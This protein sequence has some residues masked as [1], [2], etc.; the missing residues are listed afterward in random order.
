MS[1][2]VWDIRGNSV[3]IFRCSYDSEIHLIVFTSEYICSSLLF[4][5]VQFIPML[6]MKKIETV[7]VVNNFGVGRYFAMHFS[8]SLNNTQHVYL[9][10][11]QPSPPQVEAK[12][13]SRGRSIWQ[14]VR[15]PGRMV[16]SH[17][18]SGEEPLSLISGRPGKISFETLYTLLKESWE[19]GW[20]VTRKENRNCLQV[21]LIVDGRISLKTYF[22]NP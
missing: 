14:I 16:S 22:T 5:K 15:R 9:S 12:P 1:L 7:R 11:N 19:L 2:D 6:Q 20:W 13:S 8:L 21:D 17:W 10:F 4:Y 18:G 3:S